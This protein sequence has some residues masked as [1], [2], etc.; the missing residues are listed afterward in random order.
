MQRLPWTSNVLHRL[1]QSKLKLLKPPARAARQYLALTYRT[2]L[3]VSLCFSARFAMKLQS[4]FLDQDNV[5]M[6]TS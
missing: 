1:P 2:T 5:S 3:H 4:K 6:I